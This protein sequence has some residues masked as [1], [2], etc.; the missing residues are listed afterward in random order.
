MLRKILTSK[1]LLSHMFKCYVTTYTNCYHTKYF[2]L[3][4]SYQ[5][6]QILQYRCQY[7]FFLTIVWSLPSLR[8]V[9]SSWIHSSY[10]YSC[11]EK[12]RCGRGNCNLKRNVTNLLSWNI[13]LK[14]KIFF[15]PP[16]SNLELSLSFSSFI[17]EGRSLFSQ[18]SNFNNFFHFKIFLHMSW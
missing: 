9:E 8:V 7:H 2:W 5:I 17:F 12:K 13:L 18:I 4:T 11:K 10:P 15:E 1:H 3:N 6:S 16:T 14:K